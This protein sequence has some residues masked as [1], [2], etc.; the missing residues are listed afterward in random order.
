MMDTTFKTRDLAVIHKKD[1]NPE[2]IDGI[3][4]SVLKHDAV[5]ISAT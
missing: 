4:S 1:V 5:I 3:A 2:D